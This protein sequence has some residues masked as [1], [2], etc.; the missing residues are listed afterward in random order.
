M[1]HPCGAF[2]RHTRGGYSLASFKEPIRSGFG[3]SGCIAARKAASSSDSCRASHRE[4]RPS[5]SVPP[6]SQKWHNSDSTTASFSSIRALSHSAWTGPVRPGACVSRGGRAQST[7]G[8]GAP[9]PHFRSVAHG[10]LWAETAAPARRRPPER[11]HRESTPR[12]CKRQ[13]LPAVAERQ[14][15]EAQQVRPGRVAPSAFGTRHLLQA[16]TNGVER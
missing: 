14:K 16:R 10:V 15:P 12:S 2:I 4:Q 8:T 3:C 6:I 5:T 11:Q 9:R 13:R 7:G 1:H